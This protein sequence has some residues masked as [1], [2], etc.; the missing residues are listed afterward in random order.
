M[1]PFRRNSPGGVPAPGAYSL[2]FVE[3]VGFVLVDGSDYGAWQI[4][5]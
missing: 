5:K 1:I 3:I 2:T 4:Q